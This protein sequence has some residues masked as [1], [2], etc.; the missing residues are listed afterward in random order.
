MDAQESEAVRDALA[1]QVIQGVRAVRVIRAV[2]G[3]IR[4]GDPGRSRPGGIAAGGILGVRLRQGHPGGRAEPLG[5]IQD[6]R[7]GRAHR[8]DIRSRAAVPTPARFR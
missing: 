3:G 8:D 2:Q 7:R 4:A 5:D 1:V 6:V